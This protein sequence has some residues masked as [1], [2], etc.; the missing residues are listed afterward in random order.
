MTRKRRFGLSLVLAALAITISVA[1]VASAASARHGSHRTVQSR[2]GTAA[3]A[4]LSRTRDQNAQSAGAATRTPIKHLVVIFQE[5]VSFDHY[6]GTYP[7]A[8]N[9]SGEPTFHSSAGTP[10]VN[11]LSGPLLTNNPNSANPQR[12]DRSQALTC[13]QGHGYMQEQQ[14]FDNGAM[15]KFVQNTNN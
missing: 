9:P 7:R 5:N 6:F 12:L 15:D 4:G 14:A 2:R 8:T 3:R 13:D 10:T 1:A 11:G